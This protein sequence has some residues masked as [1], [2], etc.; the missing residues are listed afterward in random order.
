MSSNLFS[1]MLTEKQARLVFRALESSSDNLKYRASKEG[2]LH[3][4]AEALLG[5]AAQLDAMA[6]ELTKW[7]EAVDFSLGGE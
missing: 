7:A 4:Y 1:L 3:E 5:E 2:I 6:T